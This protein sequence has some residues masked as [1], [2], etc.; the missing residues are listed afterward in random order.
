MRFLIWLL[1]A[2]NGGA[3]HGKE[4]TDLLVP[5]GWRGNPWGPARHD[6]QEVGR[7]AADPRDPADEAVG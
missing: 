1:L 2:T 7:A 4:P 6:R 3:D 5:A